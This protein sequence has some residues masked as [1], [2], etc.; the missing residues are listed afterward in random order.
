MGMRKLQKKPKIVQKYRREYTNEWLRLLRSSKFS[1]QVFRA[2]CTRDSSVAHGGRDD[3]RKHLS[4]KMHADFVKITFHKVCEYIAKKWP[5]K[6]KFLEHADAADVCKRKN[7]SFS[8]IEFLVDQFPKMFTQEETES[9]ETE[10]NRFQFESFSFSNSDR[11][12]ETWSE[13]SKITD[14][15]GMKK[16]PSLSKLMTTVLIPHSSYPTERIFSLEWK[17]KTEFRA[18]MNTEPLSAPLVDKIQL[19]SK[20]KYSHQATFTK[21]QLQDAKQATR[22]YN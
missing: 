22:L 4:S 15:S 20:K 3:C 21:Q 9:L 2:V 8:S 14:S 13:I 16:Y 6:T 19:I 12:D 17:N 5:M 11:I 18:N 1:Y 7:K 10:F